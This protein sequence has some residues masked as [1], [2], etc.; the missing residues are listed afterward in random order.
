MKFKKG[1][2]SVFSYS[3]DKCDANSG[4][5][6]VSVSFDLRAIGAFKPGKNHLVVALMTFNQV[7]GT[8]V[9]KDM[10]FDGR[11]IK[12]DRKGWNKYHIE[13]DF[14]CY[15]LYGVCTISNKYADVKWDYQRECKN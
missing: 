9:Y 10:F 14:A 3:T 8:L 4:R 5:T 12:E 7:N 2:F 13:K 1:Y 15:D 11:V 6:T